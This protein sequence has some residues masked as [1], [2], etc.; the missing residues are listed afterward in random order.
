MRTIILEGS[1]TSGKTTVMRKL[2]EILAKN[3]IKFK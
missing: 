3:K 2:A 1:S